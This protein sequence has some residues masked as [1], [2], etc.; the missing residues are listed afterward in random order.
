M[1]YHLRTR[2][3]PYFA[4]CANGYQMK[5]FFNVTARAGLFEDVVQIK[6]SDQLPIWRTKP[7]PRAQPYALPLGK[8][9]SRI[10]HLSGIMIVNVTSDYVCEALTDTLGGGGGGGCYWHLNQFAACLT[11]SKAADFNDNGSDTQTYFYWKV[12]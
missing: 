8:N 10:S 4:D 2:L 9:G 12:A 3:L 6:N 11:A 7:Q 5:G 1:L